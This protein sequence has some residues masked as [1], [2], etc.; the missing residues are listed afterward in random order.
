MCITVFA[1]KRSISIEYASESVWLER[2]GLMKIVVDLLI[3]NKSE[4]PT[5]VIHCIVPQKFFVPT[6]VKLPGKFR[7]KILYKDITEDIVEE[8]SIYSFNDKIYKTS[9]VRNG[10]VK[11]E[12]E[13]SNPQD[14][15]SNITYN[16]YYFGGNE[17]DHWSEINEVGHTI[18]S[19]FNFSVFEIKLNHP[20]EQDEARWFRWQFYSLTGPLQA[21]GRKEWCRDLLLNKLYYNY[22]ISGPGKVLSSPKTILDTFNTV[23]K[24]HPDELEKTDL[25]KI[26][27]S[28]TDLYDKLV[29][30]K[31]GHRKTKISFNDWRTRFYLEKLEPFTSIQADDDVM[32]AGAQPNIIRG[33]A[34]KY[35][36]WKTGKLNSKD[37]LDSAY[38][39]ISI[40]TRY[41]PWYIGIIPYLALIALLL[42]TINLLINILQ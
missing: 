2:D 19:L 9:K 30:E 17:M 31:V 42:A 15:A 24:N 25:G 34:D 14:A 28:Y 33:F 35:Y 21:R 22:S 40:L 3:T 18:L 5:N 1:E 38:F 39:T 10:K 27:D 7:D 11:V 26:Y 8:K 13:I 37:E 23:I 32:A 4:D 12:L 6:N 16:G 29:K 36:E 41:Q 20:L